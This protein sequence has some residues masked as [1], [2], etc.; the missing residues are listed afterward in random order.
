VARALAAGA[1][2]RCAADWGLATTGVA[3]PG[4][5]DGHAAG[6]VYLGLSGPGLQPIAERLDLR[7][8]RPTVRAAA[9]DRA[10][11]LLLKWC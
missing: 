6:E 1:V 5:S 3:G 8:D 4:P 10:L 11:A 7:G 9:V 2:R